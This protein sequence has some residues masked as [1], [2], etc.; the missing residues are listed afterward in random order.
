MRTWHRTVVLYTVRMQYTSECTHTH[1]HT[2]TLTHSYTHTYTHTH[3][4]DCQ[5]ISPDNAFT[6]SCFSHTHLHTYSSATLDKFSVKL[7]AATAKRL[8]CGKAAV[9]EISPQHVKFTGKATV[10]FPLRYLRRCAVS[11]RTLTML[12]APRDL[13]HFMLSILSKYG[14]FDTLLVGLLW[15][16]CF[17]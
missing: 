2:D 3:T 5:N 16:G 17:L 6:N 15:P 8:K 4:H 9:C 12:N 10:V 7:E 13:F 11:C 14:L 1:T